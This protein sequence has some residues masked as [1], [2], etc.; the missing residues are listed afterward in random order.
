MKNMFKL[1]LIGKSSLVLTAALMVGCN[2]DKS[3][4]NIELVQDMMESPAIK[5]QEYDA[6]SPNG[7]GMRIP[8]EGTVPVGFV[9]ENLSDL[10][11]AE[12][13]LKNPFSGDTSKDVLMTGQKFFVTNCGVCHGN[14]GEGAVEAKS[15]IGELMPLKPPAVNNE[16]ITGWTD[17]HIYFVI[18]KGQGL[19]GPYASHIPKKYRWQVV[20][21]IR[22][23]QQEAKK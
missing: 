18:S 20:N 2:I 19:M 22:H 12:K 11:V 4:P 23:L 17:A 3:K 21:Y 7:V 14:K 15:S 13:E 10:T 1:N 5:A 16:K 9:K 8:V 6:T